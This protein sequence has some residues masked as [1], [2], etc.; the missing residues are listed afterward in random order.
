MSILHK[1]KSCALCAVTSDVI[2]WSHPYFISVFSLVDYTAKCAWTEAPQQNAWTLMFL[3][4]IFHVR[5]LVLYKWIYLDTVTDV[6]VYCIC[7]LCPSEQLS[8]GTSAVCSP[9]LSPDQCRIVYLECS[10]YGPHMQCS[11]LCMVR[12]DEAFFPLKTHVVSLLYK[13]LCTH[14]SK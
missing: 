9:R 3:A 13:V 6:H 7:L 8:S 4:W 1:P 12:Q 11:R 10:V 14:F 5:E 2:R